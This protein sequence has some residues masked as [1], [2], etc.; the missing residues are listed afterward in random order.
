VSRGPPSAPRQA[1]PALRAWATGR[2]VTQALGAVTRA[3][4]EGAAVLPLKGALLVSEVYRDGALRPMVDLDLL[5][6]RPGF[7]RALLALGRAGFG[8]QGWSADLHVTLSVPG[9]AGMRVD[10]HGRPLPVGY[11]AVDRRW[12]LHGARRVHGPPG[13]AVLHPDLRRAF[14]HLLGCALRDLL[15]RAPAHVPE[16]LRRTFEA[17]G[18]QAR[19]LPEVIAEARLRLASWAVLEHFTRR[20][21]LE[22][23]EPLRDALRPS[24]AALR[25]GRWALDA[26]AAYGTREPP[27]LWAGLLP[28]ALADRPEDALFGTAAYGASLPLG[29]TAGLLRN[30]SRG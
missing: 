4:G 26:L 13:A 27:A 18:D 10:L 16:D 1:S 17:L 24:G 19:A 21:A 7:A 23:L 5:A 2:L 14:V 28:L 25:R 15:E 9:V 6:V 22:A 8:V 20:H 11:G 3:L 12:L 30:A 29:W